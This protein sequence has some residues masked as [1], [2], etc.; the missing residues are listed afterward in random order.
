[1]IEMNLFSESYAQARGRFLEA[2]GYPGAAVEGHQNLNSDPAQRDL[3]TD[4]ALLGPP[5][6]DEVLVLCS[7]THGV[8]G[9]CG[10]AIQTGLLQGGLSSRLERQRAVLIHALN[11]YGFANLRRANE[12]NVDLNRNF[13]DH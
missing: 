1:M 12:D 6:A 4:V 13:V 10:S 9:F 2:C 11:P 3:W 8:E 7:G 5:N